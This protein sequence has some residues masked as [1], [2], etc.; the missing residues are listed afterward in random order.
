[1]ADVSLESPLPIVLGSEA[2]LTQCFSNLLDNAVK[3]VAPGVKPRIRIWA[4]MLPP[5]RGF[6]LEAPLERFVRIFVQDNGIGIAPENQDHI[7]EIFHRLN[8]RYEG[9]GI[10]L[11]I[12]HKT[13]ERLGGRVGLESALGKGSTFWFD[14]RQAPAPNP[15]PDDQPTKGDLNRTVAKSAP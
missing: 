5:E 7:F 14:L 1:V 10:G 2:S 6:H 9:T 4:E 15:T 12:V 3:F 13:M 8:E 11:A